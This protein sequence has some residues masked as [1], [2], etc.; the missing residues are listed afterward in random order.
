MRKKVETQDTLTAQALYNN[1]KDY[2]VELE[3]DTYELEP[4]FILLGQIRAFLEK[5]FEV[6]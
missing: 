6:K 2:V 3:A 5:N 1:L 4:L